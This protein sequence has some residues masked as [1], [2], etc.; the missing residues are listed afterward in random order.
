[1]PHDAPP[2]RL[3]YLYD[4]YICSL[5]IKEKLSSLA[6]SDR[7]CGV[8]GKGRINEV[9]TRYKR[10]G[11]GV[12]CLRNLVSAAAVTIVLNRMFEISCS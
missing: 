4:I 10:S 5:I 12:V 9:V 8:K 1:V 2:F 6:L 3:S 11:D 7:F